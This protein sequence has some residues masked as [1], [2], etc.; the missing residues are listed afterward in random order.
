MNISKTI[1]II[2]LIQSRF[3]S[4][5]TPVFSVNDH[6]DIII[7]CWCS[8][9]ETFLIILNV[10]KIET[11]YFKHKSSLYMSLLSHVQCNASLM[12]TIIY[13]FIYWYLGEGHSHSRVN[14]IEIW[15]RN[16]H[17]YFWFIFQ[18]KTELFFWIC[19][20]TLA[21]CWH[22]KLIDMDYKPQN[23]CFHAVLITRWECCQCL[24]PSHACSARSNVT[25]WW[26]KYSLDQRREEC[27]TVGLFGRCSSDWA[28]REGREGK[29][30]VN[31]SAWFCWNVASGGDDSGQTPK[32]I[33]L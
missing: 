3:L 2:N 4:I 26:H 7:I 32:R 29:K 18:D 19:N 20:C 24:R 17:Q 25:Q 15:T 28:N 14:L 33:R 8:A 9:E 13:Y 1:V 11:F 27:E 23:S 16:I 30:Q 22:V 12:N 6:S 31:L 10:E 5:I 21:Y